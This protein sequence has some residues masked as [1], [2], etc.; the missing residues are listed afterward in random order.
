MNGT[1]FL[2]VW[3]FSALC[4]KNPTQRVGSTLLPQAESASQVGGHVTR[5]INT[6]YAVSLFCLRQSSTI[7]SFVFG[8]CALRAQKPNTDSI[9]STLLP[10][11]ESASHVGDHVTRVIRRKANRLAIA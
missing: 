3:G 11:A 9:G 7:S 2:L 4:A 6:T 5:V 10:Q 8:F 1:S